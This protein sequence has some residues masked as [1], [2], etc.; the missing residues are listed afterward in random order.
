MSG[1]NSLF[2]QRLLGIAF[3][4]VGMT[5]VCFAQPRPCATSDPACSP[6]RAPEIDPA[7]A[8]T[9]LALLAGGLL[10]VRGRRRSR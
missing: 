3:V 4:L 5:S 6:R 10:V 8:T 9:A 2:A 7:N 1:M